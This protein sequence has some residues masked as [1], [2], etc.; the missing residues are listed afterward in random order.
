MLLYLL[1]SSEY[2][3]NEWS[4]T[5]VDSMTFLLNRFLATKEL[6]FYTFKNQD[7]ENDSHEMTFDTIYI[8]TTYYLD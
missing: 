3:R 6:I 1:P 8:E 2:F 7:G 4:H 5:L